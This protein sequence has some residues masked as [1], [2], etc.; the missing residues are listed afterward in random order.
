MIILFPEVKNFEHKLKRKNKLLTCTHCCGKRDHPRRE[1]AISLQDKLLEMYVC[2]A[3]SDVDE[4]EPHEV[5]RGLSVSIIPVLVTYGVRFCA[6]LIPHLPQTFY[7][8]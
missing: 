3:S 1:V 8:I 5:L 7:I 2:Y 4:I 6:A